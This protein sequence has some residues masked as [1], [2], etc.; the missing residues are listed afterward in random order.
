MSRTDHDFTD[1]IVN[2]V[3]RV[4]DDLGLQF[5]SGTDQDGRRYNTDT[6]ARAALFRHLDQARPGLHA[7]L[8]KAEAEGAE[9]FR[10]QLQD[11]ILKPHPFDP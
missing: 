2:L 5:R 9:R 11:L 10:Q 1:L 7:L 3:E 6:A 4:G 8:A